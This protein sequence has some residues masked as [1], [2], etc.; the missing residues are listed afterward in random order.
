MTMCVN[1]VFLA[2]VF[3]VGAAQAL[4]KGHPVAVDYDKLIARSD[5]HDNGPAER[6]EAGLPIGNGRMGSLLWTVPTALRMQINRVDVFGN[7]KN[8]N[9]FPQ[10][11]SDYCGGCAF[12]DVS[13]PG[14]GDAIFPEEGTRQHLSCIDGLATIQGLGVRVR[15]LAWMDQDVMA[16]EV[17]DERSHPDSISID[18]RMLRFAWTRA[19]RTSR[20][21]L[22]SVVRT[23]SQTATSRLEAKGDSLVLTQRFEEDVYFC[24]SAVAVE[25]IGRDTQIRQTRDDEMSL[26]VAPGQGTFTVLISSAAT[27]NP[28]EDV[29]RTAIGLLGHAAQRQFTGLHEANKAW[30]KAFWSKGFISL[31]SEDGIADT[32][33]QNYLYYLYIMASSSRGSYP[34]K[35][36]GMIWITGG[37]ERQWGSQYWG[38]N[39]SCLYNALFAANRLD[40]LDPMFDMYTGMMTSCSKAAQQQ[41]GSQG[42]FLPETFAFDGLEEMPSDIAAEMQD[43]YL[44]RQPW[45]QA[46]V[47]FREFAANKQPHSSRWNWIS[48]GQWVNG[49]WQPTER[50][51]APFG[52]VTHI[53]SRGAKI[54]YQF[55]MQY[56]YTLDRTWLAERAYPMI[57]GVAEFYRNLPNVRQGQDGKIHIYSVNSNESVR[58]GMDTDEE[59]AAMQG[60]FPVAIGASEILGV[61]TELRNTWQDFLGH[62]APLAQSDASATGTDP[63]WV[64]A[65]NTAGGRGAGRPDGNTMPMWF[66]DLCTLEN[67]DNDTLQLANNTLDGYR[68]SNI[69]VLSKIGVTAAMMGRADW[70]KMLLPDQLL[71][72][73]RAP[74]MANRMDQREG[75]QTTSAQR[76]GRV[77]D[78]LHNALLQSVPPGPAQNPVIRVYPAWP[79]QW[80]AAYTLLA[81]GAFLVSSSMTG[82]QIEF[83]Q[84]QS[85]KG[86]ECRLRNPWPDRTVTL[87]RNG[88]RGEDLSGSLLTFST[89]V[90]ETIVVAIKGVTPSLK[91]I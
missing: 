38:A 91:Q 52:A 61:D 48:G 43:L 86:G 84:I 76:L 25:V 17:T 27:F 5:L 53:F 72:P 35:F 10:R 29:T 88:D 20:E 90:D 78:A 85:Q 81:R 44:M 80:D 82:G 68:Q 67:P 83:V 36:N 30:W 12:V 75:R 2:L 87:H 15:A 73:D 63:H 47:R 22:V 21:P 54:A 69:G 14:Y 32:I 51:E 19:A 8:T 57:K 39:Q 40:L 55:W 46:S 34:A 16:L 9:S 18:L 60:I 24:S 41:W 31:H 28:D 3:V 89:S 50:A 64:R 37:D 13:V 1:T 26:V 42:I 62:L 70:V 66:F 45:A 59:I 11:Y 58:D 6:S 71:N 77:A 56:E 4:A 65:A 23:L 79:K 74:I 49:R 33:A 7:N